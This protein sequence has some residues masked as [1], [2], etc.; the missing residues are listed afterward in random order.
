MHRPLAPAWADGGPIFHEL[1]GLRI[2]N[3]RECKLNRSWFITDEGLQKCSY[4]L[5][6][7]DVRAALRFF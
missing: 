1:A 2:Y 4:I 5:C 6:L 7:P 3:E